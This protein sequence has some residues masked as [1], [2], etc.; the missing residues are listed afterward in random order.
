VAKQITAHDRW[1]HGQRWVY[2]EASLQELFGAKPRRAAPQVSAES[3]TTR[4]TEKHAPLPQQPYPVDVS[5]F[6][7][8]A[9][10]Q[11]ERLYQAIAE[12]TQAHRENGQSL[13][14]IEA[15]LAK[16]EGGDLISLIEAER[17]SGV[18]RGV[19]WRAVQDGKIDTNGKKGRNL[20]ISSSG[21]NRWLLDRVSR[22]EPVESDAAVKKKLQEAAAG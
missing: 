9:G 20:R 8:Q 3:R 1:N 22:P 17:L 4:D 15:L 13:R 5:R 7:G 11:I 2:L 6:S 16:K 19:I 12:N 18:N 10:E 14:N 21:F